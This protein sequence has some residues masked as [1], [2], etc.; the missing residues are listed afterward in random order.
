MYKH[1]LLLLLCLFA[2]CTNAEVKLSK[3][4]PGNLP[5][6]RNGL[7]NSEPVMSGEMSEK[8]KKGIRIG[9]SREKLPFLGKELPFPLNKETAPAY[10]EGYK[11]LVSDL[12]GWKISFE[13][14]CRADYW[15]LSFA[16]LDL[17]VKNRVIC[18]LISAKYKNT[19]TELAREQ[20]LLS[21]SLAEEMLSEFFL[22]EE[23]RKRAYAPILDRHLRSFETINYL[24]EMAIFLSERQKYLG[25]TKDSLREKLRREADFW[26]SGMPEEQKALFTQYPYVFEINT[27]KER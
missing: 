19:N 20:F 10:F 1:L 16:C 3:H 13:D 11:E 14:F 17:I 2:S 25:R 7:V 5:L 4:G 8:A 26:Y 22:E 27:G 15:R 18:E 24:G 12:H 9:F 6:R 23:D 21:L